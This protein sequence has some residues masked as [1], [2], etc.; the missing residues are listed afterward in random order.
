MSAKKSA[1]N[2]NSKSFSTN[3]H[4]N[5]LD[6]RMSPSRQSAR[7]YFIYE[8]QRNFINN[9]YHFKTD[10]RVDENLK[11]KILLHK[12]KDKE[13]K[14]RY[15]QLFE[16][17]IEECNNLKVQKSISKELHKKDQ[18]RIKDLI[19]DLSKANQKY[20]Q[21]EEKCIRLQKEKDQIESKYA[22]LE[23]ENAKIATALTKTKEEVAKSHMECQQRDQHIIEMS[24][25]HEE[26]LEA[27]DA[28]ILELEKKLKQQ[29]ERYEKEIQTFK[30]TNHHLKECLGKHNGGDEEARSEL[31]PELGETRM[32]LTEKNQPKLSVSTFDQNTPVHNGSSSV[33]MIKMSVIRF[34]P[35]VLK[36]EM[37]K[38]VCNRSCNTLKNTLVC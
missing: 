18:M 25:K 6:R 12:S 34:Y 21:S 4:L 2:K 23:A 26:V 5:S 29:Q 9:R 22:N 16:Q 11:T 1:S 13:E 15:K 19:K 36:Q 37:R 10:S 35:Q 17:K 33:N 7:D 3:P 14:Q 30:E 24:I 8:T 20:I 38:R 31:I 28:A 27:K 32:E